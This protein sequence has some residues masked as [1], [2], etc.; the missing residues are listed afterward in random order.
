MFS[1]SEQFSS[2]IK[3]NFEAQLAMINALTGTALEGVAKVIELNVGAAKASAA[4]SA[5]TAKQLLSAKDPQEF[6]ALS[7]AQAQP[8]TEK[9]LA[10]GRHL[11]AIASSTHVE[12]TKTTEAQIANAHSKVI[13]LLNEVA[14]NAPAGS[15][16]AV[17]ILKSSFDNANAG[18]E[19][20]TKTAKQAV[21]ALETNL[22]AV[23]DQFSQ[24]V[25]KTVNQ[26]NKK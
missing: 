7:A 11:A 17:A 20:L 12:F 16:S 4:E 15:E 1:I 8:N 3:A 26:A 2:A 18:Y 24:T 5:V 22:T 23:T 10:Y 6:F 9:A 19:Q 14:K 13:G 21:E 25:G